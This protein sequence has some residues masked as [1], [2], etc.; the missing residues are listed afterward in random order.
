MNKYEV[1]FIIKPDLSQ[2]QKKALFNQI[3]DA[4]TK[5]KGNVLQAAIWSEKRRLC[6]PIK[7]Y[8][9]ALYY[10]MNFSLDPLAITELR[11][12]YKLNE[13]ILRVLITKV[14]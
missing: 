12:V 9:E 14:D 2:D 1:M 5:N 7:K 13:N 6:F 11:R 8:Q 4:L 3:S 10:L